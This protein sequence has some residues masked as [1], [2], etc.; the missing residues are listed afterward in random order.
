MLQP[1]EGTSSKS[2]RG[3]CY[4][5]SPN[6]SRAPTQ[7]FQVDTDQ[8]QA[9]ALPL[10][11]S[12]STPPLSPSLSSVCSLTA[13][14]VLVGVFY[15]FHFRVIFFFLKLENASFIRVLR[16]NKRPRGGRTEARAIHGSNDPITHTHHSG[17]HAY[18]PPRL[19]EGCVNEVK[20]GVVFG[21]EACVGGG[22]TVLL[23]P[24]LGLPA[25][26]DH[27]GGLRVSRGCV[28]DGAVALQL[29]A[30]RWVVVPWC[31]CFCVLHLQ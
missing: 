7:P 8:S 23:F 28:C 1:R 26:E 18:T 22:R 29:R 9:F 31:R 24:L 5:R 25:G 2:R 6:T 3:G 20:D 17:P 12:F 30:Q 10:C 13:V 27:G 15:I 19:A 16:I 11:A 14:K 21:G 4:R